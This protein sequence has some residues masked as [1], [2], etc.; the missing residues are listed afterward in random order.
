MKNKHSSAMLRSQTLA[1][2]IL[3]EEPRLNI[4]MLVHFASMPFPLNDIIHIA[5]QRLWHI[6]LLI[7]TTSC[8]E[9]VHVIIFC[10]SSM[11]IAYQHLTPMCDRGSDVSMILCDSMSR[12]CFAIVSTNLCSI[13]MDKSSAK[14]TRTWWHYFL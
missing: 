8:F 4:N 13:D 9:I 14:R 6:Y 1:H 2:S 5:Y 12:S 3:L 10:N 7:W 11:P